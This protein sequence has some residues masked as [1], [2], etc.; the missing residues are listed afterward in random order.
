MGH[1]DVLQPERTLVSELSITLPTLVDPVREA[2]AQ[3]A[4]TGQGLVDMARP[5]QVIVLAVAVL[6]GRTVAVLLVPVGRTV[7]DPAGLVFV[8]PVLVALVFVALVVL[9]LVALVFVALVVL[10]LVFVALVFVAL[11]VLVLVFVV[12]VLVALVFVVLVFVVLE[13]LVGRTVAVLMGL[14]FVVLV[15]VVLEGLV[16][17]TVAVLVGL[18]GRT[19][20]VLVGL[21]GRTVAVLVGLEVLVLVLVVVGFR[22]KLLVVQPLEASAPQNGRAPAVISC[23][24]AMSVGV[25]PMIQVER[26]RPLIPMT[27][28]ILN[29]H[30][31]CWRQK[32]NRLETVRLRLLDVESALVVLAA[33]APAVQTVVKELVRRCS[34]AARP[35]SVHR[36]H[37][38]GTR[39]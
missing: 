21:V 32:L 31:P 11:V 36:A 39:P 33:D 17:R 14:V 15:F 27:I 2:K 13:G 34:T 38:T 19:V 20:A 7:A 26:L 25:H 18:V 8:A 22:R 28:L 1:P 29:R 3:E 23:L 10:V 4:R 6:L 5:V 24:I 37:P 35:R 9:V 12:L 30:R 16:G